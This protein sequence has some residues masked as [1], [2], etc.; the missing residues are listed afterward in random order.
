MILQKQKK[1]EDSVRAVYKLVSPEV[2]KKKK[3]N[4]VQ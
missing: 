3:K 1:N 2:K 4:S